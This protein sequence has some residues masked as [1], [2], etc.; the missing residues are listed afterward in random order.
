[1]MP[2]T[3]TA[4]SSVASTVDASSSQEEGDIGQPPKQD[5]S[6]AGGSSVTAVEMK[7]VLCDTDE[8]F[9]LEEQSLSRLTEPPI[10]PTPRY[11]RIPLWLTIAFTVVLLTLI[12]ACVHELLLKNSGWLA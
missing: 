8:L 1:M 10:K 4:E 2:S 5:G 11:S 7:Q 9:T 12:A 6:F 3:E